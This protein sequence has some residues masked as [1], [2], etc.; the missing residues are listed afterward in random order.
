MTQPVCQIG[1]VD[2]HEQGKLGEFL[3]QN[4]GAV[5]RREQAAAA[6]AGQPAPPAEDELMAMD[7]FYFSTAELMNCCL[8]A[9][10]G[11]EIVGAAG[12]NP[13]TGVL[14]F[15]VIAPSYRRRGLG[16]QM[17]RGA[18]ALARKY[19]RASLR[20]DFSC[21][22]EFSGAAAFLTAC[23][24]TEIKRQVSFGKRL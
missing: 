1:A 19:D 24:Y 14:H 23:G 15:L 16:R 2:F 10:C 22:D 8:F 17:L 3:Q 9:R 13:F 4:I 20:L 12:V 7:D 5:W 6:A 21:V 18:E 11:A